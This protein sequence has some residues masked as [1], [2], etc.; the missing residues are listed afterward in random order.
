MM[1]RSL[2]F[3]AP[4]LF[5]YAA[6]AQ[7]SAKA[8]PKPEQVVADPK[9]QITGVA[10]SAKGLLFVNYPLWSSVKVQT[11]SFGIAFA[12]LALFPLASAMLVLG[13]RRSIR[14]RVGH[15]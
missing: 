3:T 5:A 14:H 11:G 15:R 1:M 10:V 4:L 7:G 6:P 13:R 2:R 12:I 9:Y 8:D